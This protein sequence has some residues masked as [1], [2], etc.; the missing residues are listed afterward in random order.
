MTFNRN[1]TCL[2]RMLL[3]CMLII[4]ARIVA[5]QRC[6]PL[7]QKIDL[8]G[9]KITKSRSFYLTTNGDGTKVVVDYIALAKLT[10]ETKGSSFILEPDI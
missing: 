6:I 2:V 7:T 8:G 9:S 10:G 4:P 1:I 3:L 5:D